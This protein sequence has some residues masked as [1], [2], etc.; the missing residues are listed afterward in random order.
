MHEEDITRKLADRLGDPVSKCLGGLRQT[1]KVGHLW[2]ETACRYIRN[3]GKEP[4]DD[5]HETAIA[6][7]IGKQS[8]T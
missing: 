2:D 8:I 7:A 5:D 4:V 3:A 6:G 1:A